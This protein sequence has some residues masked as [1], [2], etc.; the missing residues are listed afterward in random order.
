VFYAYD[1]I[2]KT[3]WQKITRSEE[4]EIILALLLPLIALGVHYLLPELIFFG[5]LVCISSKPFSLLN[6]EIQLGG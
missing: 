6:I 1:K 5:I 4:R 3:Y 2:A